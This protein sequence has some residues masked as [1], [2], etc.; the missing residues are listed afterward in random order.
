MNT[1]WKK[2]PTMCWTLTLYKEDKKGNQKYYEYNGDH[3]FISENIDD[4]DLHETGES[5]LAIREPKCN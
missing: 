5:K 4:K 2:L 1:K 3:S